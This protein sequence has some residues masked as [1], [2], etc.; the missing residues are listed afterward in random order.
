[1]NGIGEVK[2][3]KNIILHGQN[4]SFFTGSFF[5]LRPYYKV[6]MKN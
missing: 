1:M 4:L 2:N 3:K 6:I 5:R